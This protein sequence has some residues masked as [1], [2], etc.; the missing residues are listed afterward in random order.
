VQAARRA[1]EPRL[2][3]LPRT[4]D[5]VEARRRRMRDRVDQAERAAFQLGLQADAA[6]AAVAATEAWVSRH[7]A[8]ILSD[9]SGRDQL[10]AELRQQ[11][12]SVTSYDEAIRGLRQEIAATRDAVGGTAQAAGDAGLRLEYQAL[13]EQERRLLRPARAALPP[14]QAQELARGDALLERLDQADAEAERLKARFA[15]AARQGA[16]AVTRRLAAERDGLQRE[17]EQLAAVQLEA[18][19]V[20]GRIAFRSFSAV[21]AQFYRLVLKADVGIVDVAWSR[22]RERVER[23]QQLSQQKASALEALDRDFKV[24]AREVEPP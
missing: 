12:A 1:L 7:R 16:V 20:V 8:E 15:G 19:D 17:Q 22:K 10:G 21:R 18:R 11:R 14:G 24:L 4:L 2:Q 3:T 13:L 9:P 23:I 5:E 6:G